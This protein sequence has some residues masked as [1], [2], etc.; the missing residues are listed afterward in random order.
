MLH[1]TLEAWMEQRA[2]LTSTYPALAGLDLAASVRALLADWPG[3][4]ASRELGDGIVA[5]C[6]RLVVSAAEPERLEC[7]RR[8]IDLHLVL[9]DREGYRV[10]PAK[11]EDSLGPYSPD[12]DVEWFPAE[13]SSSLSLGPGQW[14][15]LEPG[16]AHMGGLADTNSRG[17]AQIRKIVFKI[18]VPACVYS[19]SPPSAGRGAL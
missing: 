15:L 7:H 2:R 4:A 18:P 11:A 12:G 13:G 1:G 6:K 10:A 8:F 9:E 17:T 19:A 14:L 16:E 5:N 3:D